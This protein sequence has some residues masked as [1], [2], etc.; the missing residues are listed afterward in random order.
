M[1]RLTST[2]APTKLMLLHLQLASTILLILLLI[3]CPLAASWSQ[4]SAETAHSS[5]DSQS[6]VSRRDTL[7]SVLTLTTAPLIFSSKTLAFDSDRQN[8]RYNKEWT[9]TALDVLSPSRAA[10]LAARDEFPF[11][12]WPDPIL[13]R[14]ASPVPRS[15]STEKLVAVAHALRRT[16]REKGAVGLAAQQCGIDAR[17]VF[18]DDDNDPEG[19]FLVNPRIVARSPEIDMVAWT[20]HC[21]VLPPSFSATVLRD[22]SVTVEYETLERKKQIIT[23][24]GELARAVQHEMDHDRGVLIL[25]HVELDDMESDEMKRLERDGHSQRMELAYTRYINIATPDMMDS[26]LKLAQNSIFPAPANAAEPIATPEC[27]QECMAKRMSIIQERRAMVQ[28]SRTTTRRQDMFDLSRQRA[29]LYNTTY[30]GA[31][32]PPGVPCI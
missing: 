29:A 24:Q 17:I 2:G 23:L 27:D 10:D 18:L 7:F 25:D 11:G 28:Q 32:C 19:L 21:L 14:P 20:E 26:V 9:G 30:Q 3:I 8:Y 1:M 4:K 12:Q 31:S 5:S 6:T 13:R 15:L 22:N 16:A